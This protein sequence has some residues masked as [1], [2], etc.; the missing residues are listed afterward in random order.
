[1][2]DGDSTVPL[3][4]SGLRSLRKPAYPFE[5]WDEYFLGICFAVAKK[6][7]DP[8]CQV[9]AVIVSTDNL[10][11]ATGYNGL[12]RGMLDDEE[13]LENV[14]E[15]LT[16]ICHAELNA[17][18]NAARTGAP[19]KGSSIYVTK[20]PCFACCNA[21]VQAG[22]TRIYTH[23]KRFWDDDPWDKEHTRKMTLLSQSRIR[24]DAP[25]H[26][27]FSPV[28]P[29]TWDRFA[30]NGAGDPASESS[31]GAKSGND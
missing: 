3:S 16:W 10:V 24:V 30:G 27:E 5:E 20:F 22:I 12:A 31:N 7:K 19:I 15:K 23:D 18:L 28:A 13:I 14:G 6:S 2:S 17:I 8:R 25:F 4:Q 26:R 11:V 9:G 21:I 1:M 29:L